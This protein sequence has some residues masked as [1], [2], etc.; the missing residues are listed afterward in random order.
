MKELIQFAFDFFGYVIP[1]LFVVFSIS[2]LAVPIESFKGAIALTKDFDAGLGTV[3][4][5][6]A[7]VIGFCVYPIGRFLY[8]SIGLK[9][10][11]NKINKDSNKSDL[12]VPIKYALIREHSPMNFKYVES[13]NIYCAMSHNLMVACLIYCGVAIVKLIEGANSGFCILS[14]FGANSEFWILSFLMSFCLFLILTHRAVTYFHWAAYD[15]N[16]TIC[17]LDL[18]DKPEE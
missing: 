12:S 18:K 11:G 13:W 6:V 8:K 2:I 1:G 3:L 16:A 14:F 5:I 9:L 17:S 7:Y 4:V 15:I 10:F